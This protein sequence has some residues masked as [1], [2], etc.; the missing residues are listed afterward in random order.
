MK[1]RRGYLA[2]LGE[3]EYEAAWRLQ[4]R[5]LKERQAGL[6]PDVLLLLEHPHTY[7]IGK[8][9]GEEHLLSSE[10]ELLRLGI[11]VF[12]IDRGGDI[13]YHGPGQIVGYP[14]LDLHNHYLDVHRYLR[15]LEEVIIRVLAHYGLRGTREP[16]LTGVWVEHPSGGRAKVAAIG[17]KT[18]R[19]VTMHGF[20][21][22]V[23]T[24]LSYFHRI[25][26]CGISHRQVTSMQQCLGH[27][28][29]MDEVQNIVSEEFSQVFGIGFE[30]ISAVE[31]LEESYIQFT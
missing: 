3:V 13:T 6:V 29:E 18:S 4:E 15:D 26:P 20:A 12:R 22:N 5:L 21:L 30:T 9:G 10:E 17:V 16:G 8:R 7:T 25:V 31:L 28:V 11:R 27:S 14:I 23:N 24:D 19:W 2:V 1:R